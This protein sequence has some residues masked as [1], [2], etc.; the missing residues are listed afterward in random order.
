ME[1]FFFSVFDTK[2]K[3]FSNPFVSV[4]N[5]TALRDFERVCN[6]RNSDIFTFAEDYSLYQ[7]GS[8]DDG[9]GLITVNS[10]PMLLG[11]AIQFKKE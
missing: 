10:Q 7:L 4:N 1:K 2:A 6:D 5:A 3:V 9:T 11:M 8:F